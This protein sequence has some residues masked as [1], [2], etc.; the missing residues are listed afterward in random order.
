MNEL[1]SGGIVPRSPGV[2]PARIVALALIAVLALG[3]TS[4]RFDRDHDTAAVPAG[5]KAGDLFLEPCTYPTEDGDLPADCGTLVVPE[6]RADPGSRLIALPLTR[7]RASSA[8]PG[9]PIFRLEGG[10]GISNMTF[11]LA[12]RLVQ[13]HDLV[14]V[15]Y[16]GVDGSVRLDCPEVES[17]IGRA[18]DLL[19][20][21]YF[22]AYAAAFRACADRLMEDGADLAGYGLPQ[23]VEDL[24]AARA[25]L[26]YERI[27]LL[28]ESAGTR[29]AMIYAWR[30][31]ERI[32]RSV[33]LGV[34]PPGHYLWDQGVTD[35]QIARYAELRA[36]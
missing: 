13:N 7:I 11:P 28:S 1:T 12:S 30:H 10:P 3:L 17:A 25:A 9:A 29:T 16:R 15:G 8:D 33:M 24:E 19:S 14:L 35:E 6:N 32:N 27:D 4:L 22:D 18:T 20:E 21:A 23:Q 34:N 26:G 2:T 5:A 31:P 36:G